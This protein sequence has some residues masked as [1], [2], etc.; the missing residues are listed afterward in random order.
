MIG[1][2]AIALRIFEAH[3][4]TEWADDI[5]RILVHCKKSYIPWPSLHTG[6]AVKGAT[7]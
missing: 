4:E 6:S 2:E 5:V 3:T 7:L 1:T